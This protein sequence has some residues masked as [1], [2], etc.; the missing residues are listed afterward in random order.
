MD[1]T[2][3]IGEPGTRVVVTGRVISAERI[4]TQWGNGT[5][6][7][8]RNDDEGTFVLWASSNADLLYELKAGDPLTVRATVEKYVERSG[9]VWCKITNGRVEA[10]A[11]A[12]V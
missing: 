8:L 3:H 1:V 7:K 11:L 6:I 2:A 5:G 4:E 9:T 10:E 12:L